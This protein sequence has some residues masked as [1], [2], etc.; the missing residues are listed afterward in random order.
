MRLLK[1]LTVVS[2]E[3]KIVGREQGLL[4]P[5]KPQSYLTL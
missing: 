3:D 5:G 2:G 1:Q 4:F